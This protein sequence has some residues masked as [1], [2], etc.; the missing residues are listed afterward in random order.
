MGALGQLVAAAIQLASLPELANSLCVL[1]LP[2]LPWP[3]PCYLLQQLCRR[4]FKMSA[5]LTLWL[6][7]F[8]VIRLSLRAYDPC[9]RQPLR[10][11]LQFQIVRFIQPRK[12][13]RVDFWSPASVSP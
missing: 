3:F 11:S 2:P 1:S 8:A 9:L 12:R 13:G 7:S 5:I 6:T 10:C 4:S